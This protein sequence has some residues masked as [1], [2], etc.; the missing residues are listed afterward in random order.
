M[1][2]VFVCADVEESSG[3]TRLWS[4]R[5]PDERDVSA[6]VWEVAPTTSAVTGFFD[7]VSIESRRFADGALGANCPFDKVEG[8]ALS[9]CRPDTGDLKL[10]VKCF[11]SVGTGNAGRKLVEDNV[12][13]FCPLLKSV[14]PWKPNI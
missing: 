11:V 10:L 5:L 6:T 3:T 8:E 4:Y 14:S 9:I 7:P 1:D 2:A 13:R 12:I